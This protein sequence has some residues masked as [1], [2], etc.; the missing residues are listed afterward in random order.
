MAPA[1]R[2]GLLFQ[3][4]LRGTFPVTATYRHWV[5]NKVVGVARTTITVE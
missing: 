1:Q 4:N 2:F 3:P 5:T